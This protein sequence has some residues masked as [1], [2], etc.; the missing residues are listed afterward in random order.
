MA[1][2]RKANRV[3]GI[4][5]GSEVKDDHHIIA[6]A[7]LIPAMKRNHFIRIVDVVNMRVLS[8]QTTGQPE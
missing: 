2:S 3:V 6:S 1:G 4:T 7:T 8:A 5:A